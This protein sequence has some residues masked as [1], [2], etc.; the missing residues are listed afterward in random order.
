[1]NGTFYIIAMP[2]AYDT[3]SLL[4]RANF[5]YLYSIAVDCQLPARRSIILVIFFIYPIYVLVVSLLHLFVPY[6]LLLDYGH[7]AHLNTPCGFCRKDACCR[8]M[9]WEAVSSYRAIMSPPATLP[10]LKRIV[11]AHNEQGLS[12]IQSDSAISAQVK[13]SLI[14][15]TFIDF[16]Y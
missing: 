2:I 16:E 4:R 10:E 15:L 1:M 12:I 3:T 11:A 8:H 6:N 13:P 9:T 7:I 5:R 14:S